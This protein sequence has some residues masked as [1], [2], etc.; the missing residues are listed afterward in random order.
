VNHCQNQ[1][2]E[3]MQHSTV[4][5]DSLDLKW[6][7]PYMCFVFTSLHHLSYAWVHCVLRKLI[8]VDTCTCLSTRDCFYS[9]KNIVYQNK[10]SKNTYVSTINS[11][12]KPYLVKSIVK[13][14]FHVTRILSAIVSSTFCK[15]PG[16]STKLHFNPALTQSLVYRPL[17]HVLIIAHCTTKTKL[18][19]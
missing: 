5:T 6:A 7:N 18:F 17:A 1:E 4:S 12:D 2:L 10:V 19:C 13:W 16:L 15:Q 3:C 14:K 11:A 9:S 8:L